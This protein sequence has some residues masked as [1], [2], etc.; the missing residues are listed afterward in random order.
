MLFRNC[1][2][3]KIFVWTYIYTYI[4]IPVYILPWYIPCPFRVSCVTGRAV[5]AARV[6]VFENISRGVL[7][8]HVKPLSLRLRRPTGA[9]VFFV[10]W[11]NRALL[12]F[13]RMVMF[14]ICPCVWQ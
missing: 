6:L 10:L 14:C 11:R 8:T 1:C 5:V 12:T 3:W 4:H 2:G 7:E 9:D 13:D